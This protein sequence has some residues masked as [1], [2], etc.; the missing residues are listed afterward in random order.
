[1]ASL[2]L[3]FFFFTFWGIFGIEMLGGVDA[4]FGIFGLLV[5]FLLVF[6]PSVHNFHNLSSFL[7][8]FFGWFF[9]SLFGN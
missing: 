5:F 6:P 7:V 2:T 9:F 1:M 8:D 4:V 3:G